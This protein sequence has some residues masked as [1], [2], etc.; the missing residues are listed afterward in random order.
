MEQ[1]LPAMP[2]EFLGEP[3]PFPLSDFLSASLMSGTTSFRRSLIGTGRERPVGVR[4]SPSAC[5]ACSIMIQHRNYG[6]QAHTGN[7]I[8]A[9]VQRELQHKLLWLCTQAAS[10]TARPAGRQAT[11]SRS[12]RQFAQRYRLV[13]PR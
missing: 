1:S 6:Q 3:A 2:G 7:S 10:R 5:P 13:L 9:T 8:T 11:G 12:S 4:S